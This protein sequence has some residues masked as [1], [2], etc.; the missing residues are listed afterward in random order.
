M[1]TSMEA[2]L[3]FYVEGLGFTRT[4]QWIVD[5]KIRWCWLQLEGA[6][7]MLQEF[8]PDSP[9]TGQRL[10]HG[11]AVCFQCRDAL[12]LYRQFIARGL[13]PRTPFVGNAMWVTAISDPDG[14]NLD[15]ESPPTPRKNPPTPNP[16]QPD[17]HNLIP[18]T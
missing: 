5:G 7:I 8:R 11:V 6:A 14:Y 16:P 2:S 1:V 3:R 15:F 10:G 4:K 18:D 13:T 17:T 9:F 12:A